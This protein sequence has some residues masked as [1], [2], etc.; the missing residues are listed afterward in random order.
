MTLVEEKQIDPT[1]ANEL[2]V[3]FRTESSPRPVSFEPGVPT[4]TEQLLILDH[5]AAG[6]DFS[7]EL[8]DSITPESRSALIG[9]L[10]VEAELRPREHETVRARVFSQRRWAAFAI[11]LLIPLMVWFMKP[12]VSRDVS[13]YYNQ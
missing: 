9:A 10:G 5:L 11:A 4:W 12:F 13:R 1:Y 8:V 7:A 2:K 3:V 6:T